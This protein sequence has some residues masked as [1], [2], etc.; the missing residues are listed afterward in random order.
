MDYT[1]TEIIGKKQ[2][3]Y[4]GKDSIRFKVNGV[5]HQLSTL[6]N[7]AT[8]YEVGAV[9]HGTIT[10]KEKDGK[11]YYNF[12]EKKGS[13]TFSKSAPTDLGRVEMMLKDVLNGQRTIG[14]E[15]T[16][17]KSVLSDILSKIDPIH[18]DPGF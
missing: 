14:G 9:I 1:I 18:N 4:E 8:D 15:I 2:G 5:E 3:V 10:S 6:T 12:Q 13:S 17:I 7:Q 11:T 16:A